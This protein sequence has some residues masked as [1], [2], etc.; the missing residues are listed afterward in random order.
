[1]FSRRTLLAATSMLALPAP[2]PLANA[3]STPSRAR[4]AADGTIR[5][6]FPV[7][8]ATIEG[9][10]RR[11]FIVVEI[12]TLDAWRALDRPING[13]LTDENW[14]DDEDW[15]GTVLDDDRVVGVRLEGEPWLDE[16]YGRTIPDPAAAK[17]LRWIRRKFTEMLEDDPEI[18]FFSVDVHGNGECSVSMNSPADSSADPLKVSFAMAD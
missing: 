9:E 6:R 18:D 10:K 13:E 1:M 14:P 16:T 2:V 11:Y 12:T 15:S 7:G 8:Y 5:L 4:P 3:A 17:A